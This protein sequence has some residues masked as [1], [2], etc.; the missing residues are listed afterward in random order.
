MS[1]ICP[2]R[3]FDRAASQLEPLSA[4]D[5]RKGLETATLRRPLDLEGIIGQRRRVEISFSEEGDHSFPLRWRITKRPLTHDDGL[6]LFVHAGVNP[7][8]PLNDQTATDLRW[9]REPR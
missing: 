6:R 8:R 4:I 3:I 2:D 7:R 5:F 9:I 1:S